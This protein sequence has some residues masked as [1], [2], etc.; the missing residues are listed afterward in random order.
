M[1]TFSLP[2]AVFAALLIGLLPAQADAPGHAPGTSVEMPYL[3]APVVVNGEL[4]SNAYVMTRII[5]TSPAASIT[6]RERLPFIQDAYVRDVNATPIGK[7]GDPATV[8]APAL[9]ARLLADAQR[10]VGQNLVVALEIYRIQV[11]QL[12]VRAH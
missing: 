2:I 1:R 10:I 5:T 12:H 3:I 4:V 9:K 6:I 11:A 8:D 7:P